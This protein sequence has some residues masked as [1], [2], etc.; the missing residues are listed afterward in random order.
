MGHLRGLGGGCAECL[1]ES[2]CHSITTAWKQL[3]Q[4]YLTVEMLKALYY[5]GDNTDMWTHDGKEVP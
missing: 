5:Q 4:M 1:A 2:C 3:Q